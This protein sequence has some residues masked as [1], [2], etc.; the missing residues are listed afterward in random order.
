[1]HL[2]AV[3]ETN[4]ALVSQWSVKAYLQTFIYICLSSQKQTQYMHL[5][6]V[7]ETDIVLMKAY[8][9]TLTYTCLQSQK[10]IQYW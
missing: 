7:A 4:I 5:H 1:M 2:F 10:R 8:L 9:K 6:A 3:A